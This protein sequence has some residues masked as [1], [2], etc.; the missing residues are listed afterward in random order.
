[1]FFIFYYFGS[2]L[3]LK[4]NHTMKPIIP[5]I[6]TIPTIPNTIILNISTI[7]LSFDIIPK[8]FIINRVTGICIK[9]YKITNILV[10]RNGLYF[11][12]DLITHQNIVV[13]G[14]TVAI[15]IY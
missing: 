4:H 5:I 6:E 8:L 2:F 7:L 13:Y 1:M 14:N 10:L 9:I 15:N 11:D 12:N 3:I